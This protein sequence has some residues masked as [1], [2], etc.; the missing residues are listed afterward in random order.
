MPLVADARINV[1]KEEHRED[2]RA[3]TEPAEQSKSSSSNHI[4]A[5][6]PDPNTTREKDDDNEDDDDSA[7]LRFPLRNTSQ[8]SCDLSIKKS[9]QNKSKAGNKPAS[10][11][12]EAI[13]Q[14]KETSRANSECK[15]IDDSK[16]KVTPKTKPE[17]KAK[18][19]VLGEKDD[20]KSVGAIITLE[21]FNEV[22]AS[23]VMRKRQPEKLP[24]AY[25]SSYVIWLTKLD[26]ELPK[27]KGS[28]L[29]M[30]FAMFKIEPLFDGCDKEPT[31]FI[32]ATL[33]PGQEVEMNVI[34][35]WSSMLNDLESKRIPPLQAYCSCHVIKVFFPVCHRR[36]FFLLC[37]NL[38]EDKLEII[39]NMITR[40]MFKVAYGEFPEKL[41]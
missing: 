8:A 37:F 35:I 9:P 5:T 24:P 36:L 29:S 7:P 6:V 13:E 11:K 23:I 33:K 31:K 15:A 19:E 27:D 25:G 4:Y 20:E 16:P 41:E 17:P 32:M 18:K 12:S 28:Y 40:T 21:K 14:K 30:L 38:R 3:G 10:K 2:W 1:D 39:D 22:G 34:N 26:N